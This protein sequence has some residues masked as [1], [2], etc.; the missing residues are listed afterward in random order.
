MSEESSFP[1]Y[2]KAVED[3]HQRIRQL[4]ERKKDLEATIQNLT[5]SLE[6]YRQLVDNLNDVIYHLDSL[7]RITYLSPSIERRSGYRVEEL[8]GQPFTRFVHP[9]DVQE[10]VENYRE[11]L[12]GKIEPHRFRLIDKDGTVRH[13]RSSSRPL[14]KDGVVVGVV[15]ILTEISDQIRAE[16]ELRR[17]RDQ[18]EKL[19]AE[20]TRE[21]E[22]TSQELRRREEFYRYLIEES[23]DFITVL[24]DNGIINFISPSVKRLF[25]YDPEELMGKSIFRFIHPED[26]ERVIDIAR[27]AVSEP[28]GTAQVEYRFRHKNGTYR[29]C[30]SIG[31]NLK[32]HPS[33]GASVVNTRDI[34]ERRELEERMEA[35][36]RSLLRLGPDPL[37]NLAHLTETAH[38][39]T[40]ATLTRYSRM[41]KGSFMTLSLPPQQEGR[42]F[43]AHPE[44]FDRLCFRAMSSG[45]RSPLTHKDFQQGL[46]SDPDA[47]G[48]NLKAFLLH[49]VFAKDALVGCLTVFHHEEREYDRGGRELLAMIAR[50][51]GTEEERFLY[52]EGLRD[53]IDVASHELRHPTAV[54]MGF[55]QTLQEEYGEKEDERFREILNNLLSGTERLA[56]MIEQL[57]E[58]SF[59]ERRKH[60]LAMEEVDAAPVVKRAV[61]KARNKAPGIEFDVEIEE[62]LRP[63]KADPSKLGLLMDILVDNAVKYSPPEGEARVELS[64]SD[65][66]VLISVYD[67]GSGIPEEH[68][69]R[70]FDRFYQVE[71]AQHHSKPGMGLGLYLAKEIVEAHGGK[72]WYEPNPSGGS[73]FRV[74]I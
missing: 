50:V 46:S 73:I 31:R 55:A 26:R 21:L 59:L 30:E 12:E 13:V 47:A 70:I 71:E 25:G 34:T 48:M 24:D 54:V 43:Q 58:V 53:F 10:M 60:S 15:G 69:A 5:E 17:H 11:I 41:S 9:D 45:F 40:G 1:H 4:E 65:D 22:K 38:R 16:E 67:R 42:G 33:V 37:E 63:V 35:L 23:H 44:P 32:S 49:P 2:F 27:K 51:M 19:V 74:L 72:I 64:R 68:R 6:L 66:R 7:G 61:E 29:H 57:L 18:L 3:L 20:R 56:H 28:E 8:L 39:L 62:G 36:V 52:E 14:V